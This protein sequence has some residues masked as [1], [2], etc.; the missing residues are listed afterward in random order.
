M[1][2][3]HTTKLRALGA[4]AQGRLSSQGET[5]LKRHLR[6]CDACRRMLVTVETYDQLRRE[7]QR[8]SPPALP[9]ERLEQALLAE[10]VS[11]ESP[12]AQA[13]SH[14][15]PKVSGK[16][17]ALAWPVLALAATVLLGLMAWR[18]RPVPVAQPV[19]SPAS[20]VVAVEEARIR[21]T[22]TLV[23]GDV[24]IEAAGAR[25]R[26]ALGQAVEEGARLVTAADAEVHLAL[27]GG[28]GIVVEPES[29]LLVRRLREH[30]AEL[31]LRAGSVYQRVRKLAEGERYEV[32]FGD[33]VAHVRGTGFRV[34]HRAEVEGQAEGHSQVAVHEGRVV[35]Q[36]G[37]RVIADLSAG[38][39]WNSSPD[40]KASPGPERAVH[41][42]EAEA[43]GWTR[44]VLPAVPSVAAWRIAGAR[45]SGH[46]EL[47]MRV[48]AG[49]LTLPYEDLRGRERTLSLRVATEG[50]T[51][52]E[53][54]I[55]ALIAAQNEPMGQ[56][57]AEQIAPVVR[58]GLDSLRRCYERG[59]KRDPGL[60][61]KLV[62]S[63]RV[64]P[65][66]H[67][68]RASV[69]GSE[70]EASNSGIP[71]EVEGCMQA[72]AR[73]WTFPRPTG[74]S[75]VFEVPLNLKSH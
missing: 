10:P 42:A 7:A 33:Y 20:S 29:H 27:E 8:E 18:E 40:V 6:E 72:E 24:Q 74:G 9:W 62:L 46:E 49:D 52:R 32:L 34:S 36:Q 5:R 44:L 17:I 11:G 12:R 68:L 66:G 3:P 73:S 41:G 1:S 55:R 56:L 59:L 19:S 60:M 37:E 51:L 26:A 75:V 28:G 67:V 22:V 65:D 14:G 21:G 63:I 35:V 30:S 38:Q 13:A 53:Q 45:L 61:G 43:Q 4:Y 64:A 50:S 16:L 39:S 15:A 70:K 2:A 69:A 48:P 54:D 31:V 23:A 57:S 47:A 71:L 25:A 58:A